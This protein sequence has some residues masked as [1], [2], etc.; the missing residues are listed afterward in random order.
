[1]NL[2][3]RLPELLDF[4]GSLYIHQEKAI[5]DILDG[6]CTI[7]STGTGSGKTESFLIPV[8]DYCLKE[9]KKGIKALMI[10]PMN[11]LASDQMRRIDSAVLGTDI[12]YAVFTGDTPSRNDSVDNIAKYSSNRIFYRED[13]VDQ[14]PDILITNYV[15]LDHILTDNMK[16]SMILNSHETLRYIIMDEIHTY[17]GNKGAHIKFLLERLKSLLSPDVVQIGCSATLNSGSQEIKHDGYIAAENIDAFVKKMFDVKVFKYII[18]EYKERDLPCPVS[19]KEYLKLY[20]SKITKFLKDLL[21]KNSC[22]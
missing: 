1:M 15:M 11:A 6:Y 20:N 14:I 21:Y 19:D 5:Q 18:P 10:Y 2:D 17:R 22:S 12:T 16:N 13:I 3:K 9:R 4:Y 8:I 7:I